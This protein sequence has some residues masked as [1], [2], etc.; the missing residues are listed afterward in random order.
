MNNTYCMCWKI[1]HSRSI[2]VMHKYFLTI[3]NKKDIENKTF[4]KF[5]IKYKELQL[6]LKVLLDPN[7]INSHTNI[8]HIDFNLSLASNK[9]NILE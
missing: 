5:I 4:D 9:I 7:I 2:K 3:I 1:N 8:N 6:K